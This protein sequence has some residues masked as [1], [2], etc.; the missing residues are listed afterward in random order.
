MRRSC[1]SNSGG[2]SEDSSAVSV[3][4][5]SWLLS[6]CTWTYIL[7]V[8]HVSSSNSN[9]WSCCRKEK[10]QFRNYWLT[11][12]SISRWKRIG[13]KLSN[14]GFFFLFGSHLQIW[15]QVVAYYHTMV[16]LLAWQPWL[17]SWDTTI[18]GRIDRIQFQFCIY[19]L[20]I[21]GPT[22]NVNLNVSE[23]GETKGA[24]QLI[25]FTCNS[26]FRQLP[27]KRKDSGCV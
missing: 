15:V 3:I 16:L 11:M 2:G 12:A 14:S 23:M 8:L 27:K 22:L 9:A 24:L 5:L 25:M 7:H 21:K 1:C 20:Q 6:S 18:F 17:I 4:S 13:N 26:R 19:G 10:S